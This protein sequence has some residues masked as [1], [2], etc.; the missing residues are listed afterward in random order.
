MSGPTIETDLG[1]I[2][3]QINQNLKETNQ[4][5]D[6]L[7]KDVTDMKIVQVRFEAEVKGDL[8]ALQ[9]E[10]NTLQGDLKEIKGSQKAQIWALITILATAV[11][12]TVIRFVITVPP[13]SN[14]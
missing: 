9:G 5:L 13:V 3:D 11:I 10:F 1:K 14:P 7:Q 12:G 6:A 8:K 2:L 4:K